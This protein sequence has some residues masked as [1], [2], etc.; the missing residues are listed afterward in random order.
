MLRNIFLGAVVFS[1]GSLSAAPSLVANGNFTDVAAFSSTCRTGDGKDGSIELVTEDL[2]WNK[3]VR[4]TLGK[5]N[6]TADLWVGGADGVVGFPVEPETLY[7]YSF[8]L[9]D[10]GASVRVAVKVWGEG[11]PE[12]GQ[13][14]ATTTG[15]LLRNK[16][17]NTW[18]LFKGSFTVP[19]GATRA[20][21]SFILFRRVFPAEKLRQR[22]AHT[23]A[24]AFQGRKRRFG[25]ALEHIAD[26]R[27]GNI[28]FL[29]RA[30]D[31]PSPLV[32]QFL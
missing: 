3:C 19:K 17:G 11:L 16:I 20:V 2:T 22:Q 21:L 13:A 18:K 27:P 29:C 23:M 24:N 15:V 7:D 25:V 1:A 28:R 12:K 9:K 8:A 10:A 30:I 14:V 5:A 4:L 32:H 31:R 26:R 6:G